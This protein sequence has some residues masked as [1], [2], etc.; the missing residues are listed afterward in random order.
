MVGVEGN[1]NA[2][3]FFKSLLKPQIIVKKNCV[4]YLEKNVKRAFLV[5]AFAITC[6]TRNAR[7][8]G[9]EERVGY[10]ITLSYNL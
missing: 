3:I 9:T 2:R 6:I 4:S 5:E 10:G 7:Q 1:D 8:E